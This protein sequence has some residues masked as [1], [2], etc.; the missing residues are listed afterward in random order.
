MKTKNVREPGSE[1]EEAELRR[2]RSIRIVIIVLVV[3]LTVIAVIVY[4][5]LTSS[6]DP[7]AAAKG[8]CMIIALIVGVI[9][10]ELLMKPQ[11]AM[12]D[13]GAYLDQRPVDEEEEKEDQNEDGEKEEGK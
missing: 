11:I 6:S 13:P 10:F 4:I 9:A 12:Y 1:E 5:S 8:A 7:N 3:I 2:K